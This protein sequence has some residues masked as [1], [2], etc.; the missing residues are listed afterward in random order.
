VVG[1]KK[2]FAALLGSSGGSQGGGGTGGMQTAIGTPLR[3]Q[4]KL[5]LGVGT[6]SSG[7]SGG[8][9]AVTLAGAEPGARALLAIGT[10]PPRTLRGSARVP[11]PELLAPAPRADHEG[12]WTI[13]PSAL[14]GLPAGT[15]VWLP[16]WVTDS[17]AP[18]GW[19]ASRA[20]PHRVP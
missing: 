17:T 6:G 15:E 2:P 19:R 10:E 20:V 18:G 16:A 11:A 8:G 5:M 4:G 1:G 7:G 3:A 12:T 9:T 14:R 13:E